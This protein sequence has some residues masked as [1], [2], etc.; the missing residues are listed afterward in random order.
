MNPIDDVAAATLLCNSTR[1]CSRNSR[2]ST[3]QQKGFCFAINPVL[4]GKLCPSFEHNVRTPTC[5][6][7]STAHLHCT[8]IAKRQTLM[9]GS[10][11]GNGRLQT[12]SVIYR[13]ATNRA[14]LAARASIDTGVTGHFI[15][16]FHWQMQIS[17]LRH[18]SSTQH[19]GYFTATRHS[20]S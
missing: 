4:P 16:D 13:T 3:V 14:S 5:H 1:N 7:C 9:L 19:Q 2:L 11:Y 15:L 8:A 17:I 10:H 6:E 18:H 12:M 20:V